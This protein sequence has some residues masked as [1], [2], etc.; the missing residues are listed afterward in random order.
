MSLVKCNSEADRIRVKNERTIYSNYLGKATLFNNG[1]TSRAPLIV[2]GTGASTE[3]SGLIDIHVGTVNISP[4]DQSLVLAANAAPAVI[5]AVI[6]PP[7]PS[8]GFEVTFASATYYVDPLFFT[9]DAYGPE[10]TFGKSTIVDAYMDYLM[11]LGSYP[12]NITFYD[13]VTTTSSVMNLR[14]PKTIIGIRPP[15]PSLWSLPYVVKKTLVDGRLYRV[16][17]TT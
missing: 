15:Y 12:R 5:P 2:T 7:P 16:F 3:S 11:S 10:V 1:L 6:I 8:D 9:I 14:I 13:T 17:L 4:A